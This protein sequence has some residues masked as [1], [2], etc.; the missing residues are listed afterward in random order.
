MN[1]II[2]IVMF[3]VI[4]LV[5]TAGIMTLTWANGDNPFELGSLQQLLV[6]AISA[7]LCIAWFVWRRWSPVSMEWLRQRPVTVLVWTFIAVLGTMIPSFWLQERLA[8]LPD[9][10]SEN[11]EEMM[12]F[13]GAYFVLG[14]L[15]PFSEELVFRGAV[16]RSLLERHATSGSTRS[17][18]WPIALSAILFALAHMNPAQMPHAFLLGLLLGWL[19]ARTGS[20]VPGLLVHVVNNTVS[21]L[22][23]RA[24]PHMPDL[25]LNNCLAAATCTSD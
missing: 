10:A 6:A 5:A 22:M 11:L 9:I 15:V 8:F 4:Q 19:Y 24:Y 20:I 12:G 21:Y 16:L 13:R 25:T 14:I 2:Y 1:C 17:H 23:T 18:W 7:V 3:F